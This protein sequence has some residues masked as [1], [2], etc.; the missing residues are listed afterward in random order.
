[1][2]SFGN[3]MHAKIVIIR[4]FNACIFD[5]KLSERIIIEHFTL[6]SFPQLLIFK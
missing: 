2:L 1:M 3:S 4:Q 6:Q 5:N